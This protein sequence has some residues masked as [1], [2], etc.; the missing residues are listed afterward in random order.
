MAEERAARAD[1]PAMSVPASAAAAHKGAAAS[2]LDARLAAFITPETSD[3]HIVDILIAERCPSFV[4]HW[5]WPAVRP[6]LYRLLNYKK[7]RAWAEE[8]APL[9]SGRA[10]FELLG[11]KLQLDIR[12]HGLE[13]V[14]AKGRAVVISNHPT[15]LA[16]GNAVLGALWNVRDD[17]EVMANADACRVN[18]RFA[19]IIIPVEWVMDKRSIPKT[20]ETLRRAAA[21]FAAEKMLLVFPSG[22]LAEWKNGKLTDKEWFP[23]AVSLA[24]KNDAPVIPLHMKARNSWLYYRLCDIN[25][26]L[27]D[28][29]LFHEVLNKQGSTFDLTFGPPIPPEHLQGDPAEVTEALRHYVEDVLPNDPSK[30]FEPLKG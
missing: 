7:A 18:L 22:R 8:I 11:D 30:P 1:G 28:I 5:T 15:G 3:A 14:P 25:R 9:P 13:H 29:T 19:E 20:R 26:E 6:V 16:D 24:R 23:T 21:A 4:R 12:T 10:C 27:R 2:E 17:I